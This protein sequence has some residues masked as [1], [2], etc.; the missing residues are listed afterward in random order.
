[1][2]SKERIQAL[3]PAAHKGWLYLLAGLMWSGV[4]MMLCGLAYGWLAPVVLGEAVWRALAGLAL[5]AI[6]YRFG[7]SKLADKNIDRI[8]DYEKD[9][10]CLFAFQKWTSYPLVLVMVAMGIGLR[11]Y[12]PIPKPWLAILYIGLG[13]SLFASG[14]H[15]FL[16]L[17][18]MR[19]DR[20]L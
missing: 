1:M 7:F 12:S 15:Y 5:A 3:T 19:A 6:I 14:C 17:V 4:G 8:G 18:R 11:V 2:L 10:I 9:R 20:G 16:K 13:A